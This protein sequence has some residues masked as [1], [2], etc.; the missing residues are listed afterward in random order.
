VAPRG[1]ERIVRVL[2]F[3]ATGYRLIPRG[4]G[5]ERFRAVTAISTRVASRADGRAQCRRRSRSLFAV[6]Q[7]DEVSCPRRLNGAGKNPASTA[8]GTLVARK[9]DETSAATP[10]AAR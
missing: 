1:G 2:S 9:L 10:I 7:V 6:Q 4:R 3:S 8:P 5:A